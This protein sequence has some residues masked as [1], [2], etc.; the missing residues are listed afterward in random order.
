MDEKTHF[1]ATLILMFIIGVIFGVGNRVVA[2][3]NGRETKTGDS[4][5]IDLMLI[6]FWFVALGYY[7]AY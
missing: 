6:V 2:E 1:A 5:L 4:A 7:M 3:S